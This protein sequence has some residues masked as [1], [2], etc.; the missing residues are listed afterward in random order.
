MDKKEL[1]KQKTQ[2]QQALLDGA[3]NGNRAL[4]DTEQAEFDS[5]Q[6]EIDTLKREI[7]EEERAQ[8][9]ND[10]I[11]RALQAERERYAAIAEICGTASQRGLELD[12]QDFIKRGLSVEQVNAELPHLYVHVNDLLN[13]LMK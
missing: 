11:Q 6:R 3:R 2:R 12:M 13:V 4:A 1:L 8:G 9:S 5:L 10:G 7:E